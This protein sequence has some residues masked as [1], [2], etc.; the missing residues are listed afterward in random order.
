MYRQMGVLHVLRSAG[1]GEAVMSAAH[2][3]SSQ[4]SKLEIKID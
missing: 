4:L 2:Q 1:V 3:L